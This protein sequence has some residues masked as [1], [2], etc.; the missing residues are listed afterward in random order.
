MA[1]MK[2]S[3]PL[4]A[5]VTPQGSRNGAHV[6]PQRPQ[7]LP[8]GNHATAAAQSR[9]PAA[10]GVL[11]D[12]SNSQS[13]AT[14]QQYGNSLGAAAMPA[15]CA[16]P[17]VWQAAVCAAPPAAGGVHGTQLHADA[18]GSHSGSVR[19]GMAQREPLACTA[20]WAASQPQHQPAL[21][22]RPGLV[23][24]CTSCPIRMSAPGASGLT[25]SQAEPNV[26]L[27][28]LRRQT[29]AAAA[30]PPLPPPQQQPQL[31]WQPPNGGHQPTRLLAQRAPAMPGRQCAEQLR[32][33]ASIQH[34][35]QQLPSAEPPHAAQPLAQA[36]QPEA[37]AQCPA[38][39][40]HEAA[41]LRQPL[42]RQEAEPASQ[43]QQ[44]WEEPRLTQLAGGAGTC[45]AQVYLTSF[46]SEEC[47]FHQGPMTF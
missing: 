3:R 41:E 23:P 34:A 43:A 24:A 28:A 13:A 8:P 22:Q 11:Q 33:A 31:H 7:A 44:A 46:V 5:S 39:Q 26:R 27:P 15:A 29:A 20:P 40:Q 21:L 18:G 36:P 38:Q 37:K 42:E 4:G 30:Q 47:P 32:P 19:N 2:Y 25:D 14:Q 1:R 16:T 17:A 35:T 9:Q 10:P 6:N 12:V 45:T